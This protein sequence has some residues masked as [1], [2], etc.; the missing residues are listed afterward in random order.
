MIWFVMDTNVLV[1]G[2]LRSGA[3]PG[4]LLNGLVNRSFNLVLDS[5]IFLEYKD[6][7]A[8]PKFRLPPA[9]TEPIL[10]LINAKGKWISPIGY[11][12]ILPD[13]GDRPFVEAALAA[14]V[15]LITG[16][17]KHFASVPSLPVLSPTQALE[18]M[19]EQK[20]P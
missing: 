12:G 2:F 4:I 8:R 19:R 17:L 6:V 20:P 3:P 18:A 16:N 10:A 9:V 11:E 15:P 1:S 7:L 5:R 13:E 14:G